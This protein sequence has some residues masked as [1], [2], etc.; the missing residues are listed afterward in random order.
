MPAPEYAIFTELSPDAKLMK[1]GW[2]TRVFTNTDAQKGSGITCDFA[3]GIVTGTGHLSCQ[4][5]VHGRL[6][7][8]WRTAGNDHD[9]RAGIGRLLP[10]ALIRS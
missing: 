6:C 4:G 8:R 2:N 5:T 9:T 7:H 10:A 1:D 3:T